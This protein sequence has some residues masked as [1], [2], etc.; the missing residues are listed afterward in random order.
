MLKIIEDKYG[1]IIIDNSTLPK[2]TESFAKDV[3]LL[4]KTVKNKKLL[5]A[6]LPIEKSNFIPTLTNLGFEFHN[7]DE[8]SLMLVKK[9]I[10]NSII[11]T[12]KNYIAGV[13]AVV[14]KNNKVLVI[15][16]KFVLDY[17]L[18]GGHVDKNETVKNAVIREVYEET[19]IKVK[20][21][22]IIS[23]AHF[24][25]GQF[26]ESNIH[27]ICLAKALTSKIK[28]NDTSEITEAKWI[29]VDEFLNAKY[30][31]NYN[32]NIVKK[33]I[34]NAHLKFTE[35]DIKVRNKNSEVFF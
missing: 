16:D 2:T 11:P 30:I 21:E 24:M 1:G 13:G 15:K 14:L 17:K 35:Q 33:A 23:I 22:S 12:T 8:K 32:Q 18:P 29:D 28:I 26:G 31:Y 25:S 7:C 6:K 9:L 5:W 19:G 3:K 27:I 10:C 20:F 34:N 4:I